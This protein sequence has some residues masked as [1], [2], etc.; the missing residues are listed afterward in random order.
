MA[1]RASALLIPVLAAVLLAGAAPMAFAAD[2]EK[3]PVKE[4][5][6]KTDKRMDRLQKQIRDLQQ[7]IL[8]SRESGKPVEVRV[9][10]DPDPALLALTP[11][12]DDL[13][14]SSR[15]LNATVETLTHEL[16]EAKKAAAE[17]RDQVKALNDRVETLSTRLQVVEGFQRGVAAAGVAPPVVE[18][19]P[20]SGGQQAQAEP[21]QEASTDPAQGYATGRRL[22]TAGD[23]AGAAVAFQAF[24]EQGG[25]SAQGAQARYW[26]G[27][28]FFRQ[29][30]YSDAATAYI[31]AIRGWP[32]TNWAP[33]AM[34][35][36]AR[37]LQGIGRPKDVCN[38]L[39]EL[40]R[41]YPKAPALVMTQAADARA[42]A[43][44]PAA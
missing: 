12:I 27:E 19:P 30:D 44:C 7:I 2:E 28:S 43:Q 39:D 13:E 42:K 37:S 20:P 16:D 38:T 10:T 9:A 33:D 18:A 22:F 35:K 14:Q 26:L 3:D 23:Y 29:G 17:A 25:D 5:D 32:R 31:G 11:R 24:I 36:L 21:A 1:K 34:V 40:A 15:T 41:R 6:K 4:L 8:Q